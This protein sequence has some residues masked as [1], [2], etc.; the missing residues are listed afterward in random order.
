[1]Q[2]VTMLNYLLSLSYILYS[3]NRSLSW[4]GKAIIEIDGECW[5]YR[6][7]ECSFEFHKTISM[8]LFTTFSA[9]F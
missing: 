8:S 5:L 7:D 1:L 3:R 9:S 4:N 6:M 2:T